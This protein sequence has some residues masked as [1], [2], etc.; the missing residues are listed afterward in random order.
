MLNKSPLFLLVFIFF[1]F[2]FLFSQFTVT[3]NFK[4]ST[5]GGNIVLGDAA[6][7]T[8]GT[9]DRVNDGWLRLTSD[10]G[11]QKGYAYINTSFPA[12]LGVYAEFEYKT[13]R[14]R[15]DDTYNGADGF[16]VFLFDAATGPF[17]IGGYGGS[18][19]Y[20]NLNSTPGLRGGYVGI[21]F[22]EFGNFP[23][24]NEQKNG[25]TNGEQPNSI[26][27]RGPENLIDPLQSYKYLTHKQLQTSVSANG[28]TSI[29]YNTVTATRPTNAFFYRKVKIYID[30]IG[31]PSVPKY[32]IRVR[33]K[34][35]PN[36]PD[37]EHINYDTTD[38]IPP[39]LKLGFAASTGG[40]FNMHEIRNLIITT[41]GGVRVQKNVD[42]STAVVGEDLQYTVNIHNETLIP[43][44]NLGFSD[45]IQDVDRNTINPSVFQLNSITF[46]NLGDTGNTATGFVSGTPKTT[47]LTNPF[48]S[49]LTLAANKSASFTISGKIMALPP[50]GLI[51]NTATLDVSA[52]NIIDA[53]L[54]NNVSSVS[55]TVLNP[56]VDLKIE[57]DV[58]QNGVANLLGNRFTLHVSNMSTTAKPSPNVVTVTDTM[59]TGLTITGVTAPG[60]TVSN[61]GQTY[62][63]TRTDALASGFAYPPIVFAVTPSTNGPWT[64]T[65]NLRYD[66][67]TNPSNNTASATLKALVCYNN[68]LG[69]ANAPETRMGITLLKRAGARNADNWPMSRKS[70]HIALESNTSGFVITRM[71]SVQLETLRTSGTATEGMMS[72][73]TT[74][75]CLRVFSDG[76]W[77][78]FN[79]PH[80]P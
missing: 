63:F 6:T 36:G 26:A 43:V 9:V 64:N 12:T 57:K 79:T 7:L 32:K 18:L 30:P 29:D 74:L 34:T 45:V 59:P 54:T 21:G 70:A 72:Y 27:L 55:T 69:A 40:G 19:G 41:T 42:K 3:E 38:P 68:A 24:S 48:S 23:N 61:V 73:D 37:I 71:T 47:G 2:H 44:T 15:A 10:A 22:D 1:N 31:T 28:D 5:V 35:T 50:G 60:W 8:S 52:A 78:C 75:N 65:G 14:T 53:D 67:D 49:T 16:T 25:G 56:A 46:N 76:S 20:A 13:W 11:N 4:G 58:D 62:T 33:W 17:R 77:K 39:L 80:C 66:T 51:H